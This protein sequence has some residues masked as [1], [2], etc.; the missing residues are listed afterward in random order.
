LEFQNSNERVLISVSELKSFT[1]NQL[2]EKWNTGESF[3]FSKADNPQ[4]LRFRD[5]RQY[6]KFE[7]KKFSLGLNFTSLYLYEPYYTKNF[8][9]RTYSTNP[10][11]ECF[12]QMEIND[13]LALRIPARIGINPL[14]TIVINPE[15]LFYSEMYARELLFDLGI[16]PIFY[17][18]K[19]PVKTRWF[20]APSL[21]AVLGKPVE[22]E[23][24]QVNNIR[25]LKNEPL[26]NQW[27]YRIGALTGFQYWFHPRFQVELSYGLFVT[28]NYWEPGLWNNPSNYGRKRPYFGGNFRTAVVY[29]F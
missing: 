2:E 6:L 16:E 21:S 28:N 3:T 22:V 17:F 13:G 25:S 24:I 29:K 15:N 12:F 23:R 26:D 5:N 27:G 18:R 7:P 1:Q 19:I 9:T 20:F 8:F 11:L 10:Y 14:K 4:V